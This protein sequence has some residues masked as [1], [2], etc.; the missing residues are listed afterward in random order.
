MSGG[1]QKKKYSSL[2]NAASVNL[3]ALA[4]SVSSE[5]LFSELGN[6]YEPKRHRL[7]ADWAEMLVFLHHNIKKLNFKY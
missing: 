2:Y 5:Q 3:S 1:R 6:I 7:N 4:G